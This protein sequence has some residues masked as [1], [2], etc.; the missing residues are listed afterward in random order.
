MTP[1]QIEQARYFLKDT[2]RQAIDLSQTDQNRGLDPPP[3]EKPYP[4]DGKRINLVS[5]GKWKNIDA[6]DLEAAIR[7]RQSRRL[8]REEAINLDE[9]SF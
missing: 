4:A 9:L 8:F 5:P 2:I 3:L 1:Q 7:N 6:V